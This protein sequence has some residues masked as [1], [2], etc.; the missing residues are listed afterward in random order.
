MITTTAKNSDY[1]TKE[2]DWDAY[3]NFNM[4]ETLWITSVEKW[5]LVRI[6]D[7]I[8]RISNLIDKEAAVH[9]EKITDTLIDLANYALILKIYLS[10]KDTNGISGSIS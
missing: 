4:V 7:K 8:A 2:A 1:S 9:D 6:T 3:K 10:N 5:I